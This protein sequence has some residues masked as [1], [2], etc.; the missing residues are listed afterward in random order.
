MHTRKGTGK[1]RRSTVARPWPRQRRQFTQ[2]RDG[3]DA[4][5]ELTQNHLTT[6]RSSIGAIS[7]L[8]AVFGSGA[9]IRSIGA[10]TDGICRRAAP[11]GPE[12]VFTAASADK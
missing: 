6:K 3:I 11:P 2:R 4:D 10:L 5:Q 12:P 7:V 1:K 9:Q 8:F